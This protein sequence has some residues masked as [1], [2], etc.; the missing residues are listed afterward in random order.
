MNPRDPRPD[1]LRVFHPPAWLKRLAGPFATRPRLLGGVLVGLLVALVLTFVPNHFRPSTRA[2]LT[3]DA[4]ALWFCVSMLWVMFQSDDCDMR[5]RA[6]VQDEGQHFIL[7]LVLIAAVISIGAIAKELSLA[8]TD[9]GLVKLARIGLAFVTVIV[10]WF[11]VQLVFALHY[12]HEYYGPK[13]GHPHE[14]SKGLVFP[15]DDT[16][17]YWDF[18]YFAVVIG[19]ASQTADVSFKTKALRRI[20]TVHGVIAFTFNTVVLALTIN[21][22][23]GLF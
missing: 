9:L 12:A 19:V 14:I 18:L 23:A 10:S 13:P 20:G 8:K 6:C 11:L 2:L 1:H 15:D 3:W 7:F 16:P 22:L 5:I 17:D 21:L 4:G